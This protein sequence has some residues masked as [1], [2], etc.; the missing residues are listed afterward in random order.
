MYW[1]INKL[2]TWFISACASPHLFGKQWNIIR[3]S[4]G[5]YSIPSTYFLNAPLKTTISYLIF[6]NFRHVYN[7]SWWYP[8]SVLFPR[9][10]LN[11]SSHLPHT[12]MAL[13]ISL[14]SECSVVHVCT[15][16]WASGGMNKTWLISSAVIKSQNLLR[17]R[18]HLG[19]SLPLHAEY[20]KFIYSFNIF[21]GYTL[22]GKH[23]LHCPV[24]SSSRPHFYSS[25]CFPFVFFFPS[26]IFPLFTSNIIL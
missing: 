20:L 25:S 15:V 5:Q 23:I 3:K 18:W 1:L 6:Y 19:L 17:Q 26:F 12:F 7:I 13:F 16:Q 22:Y 11:P 4:L 10:L 24:P 8:P 2:K 9:S 21:Y 14:P